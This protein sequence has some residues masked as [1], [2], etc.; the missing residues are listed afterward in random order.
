MALVSDPLPVREAGFD[1]KIDSRQTGT[2]EDRY[3]NGDFEMFW[4]SWSR[5]IDPD[6]NIANLLMCEGGANLSTDFCVRPGL[7]NLV[8]GVE[9]TNEA[10]HFLLRLSAV[11]PARVRFWGTC[12]GL[13]LVSGIPMVNRLSRR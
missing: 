8:M 3:F 10:G 11:K 4:G 2:A 12:G 1:I 7:V 13:G 6:G 9:K 5:R